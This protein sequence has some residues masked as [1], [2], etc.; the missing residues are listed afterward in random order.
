VARTV[1]ATERIPEVLQTGGHTITNRTLKALDLTKD[2]AKR[3]MESLKKDLRQGASHHLDHKTKR[4][5]DMH[6]LRFS[7]SGLAV[8]GSFFGSV[9]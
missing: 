4:R 3:A 8:G 9:I 5:K 2:Q 6:D 7:C 1:G